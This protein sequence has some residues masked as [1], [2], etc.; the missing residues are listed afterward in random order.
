M[1]LSDYQW[2]LVVHLSPGWYLVSSCLIELLFMEK[3]QW[4]KSFAIELGGKNIHL[5]QACF[6][7]IISHNK[8]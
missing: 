6:L 4:G 5:G 2:A 8:E 1:C 7:L 3:R